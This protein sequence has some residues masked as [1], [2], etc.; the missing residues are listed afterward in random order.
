[1]LQ[2]SFSVKT[3]LVEQI[4][5]HQNNSKG[6]L[7]IPCKGW[8]IWILQGDHL[9][10]S[11]L[12]RAPLPAL[13]FPHPQQ[14]VP[15]SEAASSP[16]HS[17]LPWSDGLLEGV[18]LPLP[19]SAPG[20]AQELV[21]ALGPASGW[22]HQRCFA[23]RRSPSCS[24]SWFSPFPYLRLPATSPTETG[25][26]PPTC[27]RLRLRWTFP[28][29]SWSLDPGPPGVPRVGGHRAGM[30][31]ATTI[32]RGTFGGESCSLSRNFSWGL[33]RMDKSMELRAKMIPSVSNSDKCVSC[34]IIII[35]AT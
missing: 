7:K 6:H 31:A 15:G 1:M 26:G 34:K 21:S 29:L 16:P 10:Q 8:R 2:E 20:L 11:G 13:A 12:W 35:K 5:H 30:C 32:Y 14:H 25:R 33:I 18:R 9:N 17:T 19:G 4:L 28:G 24:R 27:R 22:G 3:W 23:P